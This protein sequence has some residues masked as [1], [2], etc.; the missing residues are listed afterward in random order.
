[1]KTSASLSLLSLSL[2]SLT[3]CQKEAR[4]IPDS[5]SLNPLAIVASN[6]DS[7]PDKANFKIK[8]VKDSLNYDE[9]AFVFNR[10]A[11]PAYIETEDA[12]YL[13]GFGQG[14]LSSL[15]SDGREL[16]I[17]RLPY[18]DG[19]SMCLNMDANAAGKFYLETSYQ[20]KIP[21]NIQIWL[22]D[23]FLKDS[24]NLG[25]VKYNFNVSIS[26]TNSFGNKRFKIIV[27]RA[28]QQ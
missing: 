3:A 25:S 9:T 2:F 19:M 24:V 20:D 4:A 21:A 15:S 16:S 6:P 5:I 26:D 13:T 14:G 11:S 8:L 10:Q 12:L 1:M 18:S 7:I 28:P 27:R 17:N 22:K 23:T